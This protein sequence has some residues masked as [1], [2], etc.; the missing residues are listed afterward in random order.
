ML[1]RKE[2]HDSGSGIECVMLEQLDVPITRDRQI[3]LWAVGTSVS[4]EPDN[5]SPDDPRIVALVDRAVEARDQEA[6][7]ALYDAYLDRVYRYLYFRTNHREEAEDLTEQVFLK[8]W[9]SIPRFRWQGRPFIAWLYRLAHNLLVDHHRARRPTMSINSEERPI[10][11]MSDAAATDLGR[12]LDAN[13][14]AGALS[15]LTADQQ[16]V[17]TLKF[18]DG[19]ENVDI[20][21]ILD[22]REGAIRALQLRALLSLRRILERQGETGSA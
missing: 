10:D 3:A 11:L 22:K 20:A 16:Q 4:Q 2:I 21:D 14:L 8:A 9:E 6:F 1:V 19:L 18:I 7:G 17:I 13:L 15:E 5:R 12:S